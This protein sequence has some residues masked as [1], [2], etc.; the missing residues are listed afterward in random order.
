MEKK[1]LL[2][3]I[4]GIDGSGKSTQIELLREYFNNNQ[5]Y[6]DC[7]VHLFREPGGTLI[8]ESIRSILKD[9][10][11]KMMTD[12]CEV[13]LFSAGRA[14]LCREKIRPLLDKGD[15]V[16]VDRFRDSTEVYQGYVRGIDEDTIKSISDYACDGLVADLTI[17]LD[18]N[19][20]EAYQRISSRCEDIDRLE[21]EGMDFLNKVYEG[22]TK[23]V[24]KYKNRYQVINA[25]QDVLAIHNEVRDTVLEYYKKKI[26]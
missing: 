24:E 1:G 18:V 6:F 14:Q 8:G 23:I 17:Y 25:Y 21:L 4:E 26:G 10:K 11:F 13:L 20:Q 22:Y 7:E 19:P 5:Q 3:S 12:A 2:I 15:I 9:E 16:I